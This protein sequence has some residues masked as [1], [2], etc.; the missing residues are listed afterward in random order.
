[1]GFMMISRIEFGNVPYLSFKKGKMNSVRLLTAVLFFLSV[2]VFRGLT[3]FPVFLIY[4]I[5]NVIAYI[6]RLE[7]F[8][9]LTKLKPGRE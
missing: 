4:I 2:I 1:M 7:K 3:L 5:W 9:F 8:D 6:F